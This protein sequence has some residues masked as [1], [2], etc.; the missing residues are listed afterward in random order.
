MKWSNLVRSWNISFSFWT[1]MHF[2]MDI[3]FKESQ[4]NHDVDAI[5]WSISTIS[6]V[7][8]SE[9]FTHIGHLHAFVFH[10]MQRRLSTGNFNRNGS[11]STQSQNIFYTFYEWF[12]KQYLFFQRMIWE[13]YSAEEYFQYFFFPSI[14]FFDSRKEEQNYLV[15]WEKNRQ[16]STA[17][18]RNSLEFNFSSLSS[19]L[20]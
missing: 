15:E 17:G 16:S 10:R 5:Y 19:A 13:L 2:V 6:I 7:S 18:L 20:S 9:C 11:A 12:Q 3:Y 4:W 8:V 1:K 14:V